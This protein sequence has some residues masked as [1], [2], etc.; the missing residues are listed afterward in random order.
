M[1]GQQ[2]VIAGRNRGDQ[3][4]VSAD[5]D[6]AIAEGRIGSVKWNDLLVHATAFPELKETAHGLI[7]IYLGYLPMDS[8]LMPF[9]AYLRA[10]VHQH[11]Q[12]EIEQEDFLDQIEDHI[13]LIR[14]Y[15]MKYNTC[16]T[17]DEA[18][19]RNYENN[20]LP[21]GYMVRDRLSQ[22]LGYVPQLAH[23]LIAELWLRDIV[24]DDTFQLPS[25]IDPVDIRAMT[26]IK[27]REVLLVHGKV[28]ADNSPLWA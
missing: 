2:K 18:I 10:L 6:E 5:A 15:D 7:K 16:L 22:F 4:R 19:Y 26:L 12:G 25:T 27:Y 20:Y 8:V 17:Y 11:W 9:E 28:A 13:K 24:A 14:N 23:S 3:K 1:K 21:Y